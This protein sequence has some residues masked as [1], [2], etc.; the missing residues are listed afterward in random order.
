[1]LKD[2]IG[3]TLE[4]DGVVYTVGAEVGVYK[5]SDY[6]DLVGRIMEIRSEE[7]MDTDNEYI[8]IYCDFNMPTDTEVIEK[9][10]ERATLIYGEPKTLKDICLDGIVMAPDEIFIIS[11][12]IEQE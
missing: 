6:A 3:E 10:E 2:K 11:S 5:H 9:L 7:D 1:M 8:D 12:D 4:Y